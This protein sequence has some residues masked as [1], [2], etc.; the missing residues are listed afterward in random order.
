MPKTAKG[1]TLKRVRN[2]LKP[3]K[4]IIADS[5][6]DSEVSSEESAEFS[7]VPIDNIPNLTNLF[8]EPSENPIMEQLVAQVNNLT[9]CLEEMRNQQAQQQQALNVLLQSQQAAAQDNVQDNGQQNQNAVATVNLDSLYKIPDPIKSIPKFDGNRKQLNA[10]LGTAETTLKVF[11]DL[12]SDQQ[13]NIFVT[14]VINK[15]EGRAKDIICLAG[16]PQCFTQVKEILT[17]ALGDRQELTYY[18]SQLWQTRMTEN[19]SV[20]KYFNKIKETVQNIKTLAKQK[21]KYQNSWDAIN[22]FIE[23]D[24]LAAFLSGLKEP[25]FG[26]AQAARPDDMEAAYAF[27]CK[28]KC[29][30]TTASNVESFQKK[31]NHQQKDSKSF[32]NKFK[33]QIFDKNKL[34][35]TES[36][37]DPQP[38]EVGSTKSRLTLNRRQINNNENTDSDGS[39]ESESENNIDINFCLAER[40][41]ETT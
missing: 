41:V 8:L 19:M 21:E 27:V 31:L 20:H 38:M 13:Y 7:H 34:E 28:F 2:L 4:I 12:V 32:E 17:T 30:E 39:S 33:K 14:A 5:S 23:E 36:T 40:E 22:S 25:Y 18:K 9:Q 3:A 6:S 10:W 11:K 35:K 26:Y 24:A 15:I 37:T 1:T 16:N 29:K